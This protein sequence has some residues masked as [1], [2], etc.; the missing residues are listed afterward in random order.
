MIYS[1][2]DNVRRDFI[3]QRASGLNHV[4]CKLVKE[5]NITIGF[6]L[7]TILNSDDKSVILGRMIQNIKIC[8]KFKVKTAIASFAQNPLEMRSIHDLLSLFVILGSKTPTFLK[9][10]DMK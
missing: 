10:I 7:N 3:H 1:L 4:L 9:D 5:N 2:E 6:S 8:R